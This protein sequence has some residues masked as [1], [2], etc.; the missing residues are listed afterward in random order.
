MIRRQHTIVVGEAQATFTAEQFWSRVLRTDEG[1]WHWAGSHANGYGSF[2]VRDEEGDVRTMRA[3]RMAWTLL[4][5]DIPAGLEIDHLCRNRGCVR[6]AHL[7]LVT[8][9]ENR[10]RAARTNY[11]PTSEWAME[12]A[13]ALDTLGWTQKELA[14][15][16]GAQPKTVTD[17][18][19][20]RRQPYSRLRDRL[21]SL[22]VDNQAEDIA[23]EEVE[24]AA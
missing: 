11:D 24:A 17:W 8:P 14:D 15:R 21:R 5:G 7:E 12:V 4:V 18:L 23:V 13:A 3:H 20:G 9:V 22:V 19:H 10:A 16:I 6:P 1:C 2:S